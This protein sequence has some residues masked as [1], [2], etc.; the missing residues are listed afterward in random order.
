MR[1]TLKRS[2]DIFPEEWHVTKFIK[3]HNHE[4]LSHEHMRFL[5]VNR[6]ITPEDKQKILLYKEAGLKV[7]EIIRVMELLKNVKHRDLSFLDKDIRNLFT[8]KRKMLGANDAMSLIH[9][10][11]SS[12]QKDSKFQYVYTV[13]EQRRL[14]SL[15]WCHPKSFE[16]YEKYGDVVV[17]DT[18]YKVNAYDMPCAL[19]VG[20]NN[21]GKTVLFGSALL[22]NEDIMMN[23]VVKITKCF[24]MEILSC[25]V[26]RTS[27]FGVYFVVIYPHRLF[28]DTT[29]LLT[30][31]LKNRCSLCKQRGHTRPKCPWKKNIV[32][33][34]NEATDM[35]QAK[36]R[37][38]PHNVGLNPVFHLKH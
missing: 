25:V 30:S 36:K 5:P 4:L 38:L 29:G 15:L 14:E 11:R 8:K 13:D 6:I 32:V 7:R 19:F 28:Q 26:A 33:V 9:Y 10:M 35:S 3:D 21:H 34:Q 16:W 2:F 37:C 1:L 22:C 27:N 23:E 17:F 18:T 31:S 20:V 12:K 24:G